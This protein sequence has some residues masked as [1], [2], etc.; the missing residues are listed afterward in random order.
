MSQKPDTKPGYYY[1]TARRDNGD[2][3]LLAG[4]FLNDHQAALDAL[5][6][7]KAW[8]QDVDPRAAWYSYGTARTEDNLGPGK[9]KIPTE[10]EHAI[11][12]TKH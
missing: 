8:A 3:V 6:P 10:S 11:D 4:P 1:A 12:N 5:A 7:A 2:A 9:F